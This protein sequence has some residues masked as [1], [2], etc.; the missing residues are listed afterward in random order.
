LACSAGCGSAQGHDRRLLSVFNV[1]LGL[2]IG[3]G[4]YCGGVSCLRERASAIAV[5]ETA[6]GDADA[7]IEVVRTSI[8]QLC[9]ADHRH[10]PETLA[11]WLANKTPEIFS[12]GFRI[13][14]TSASSLWS[15]SGCPVSDSFIAAARSAC[16]SWRGYAAPGHRQAKPRGIRSARIRTC[17]LALPMKPITIH[18]Y[19]LLSLA[20][21]L[22]LSACNAYFVPS[23][24]ILRVHGAV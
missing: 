13:P 3:Q 17:F 1:R 12:R 19:R 2:T 15:A 5:R 10:D 11:T 16:S 9:A 8:T 20:F 4:E 14:T 21:V 24:G 22:N 6:A 23:L 7:V 18:G